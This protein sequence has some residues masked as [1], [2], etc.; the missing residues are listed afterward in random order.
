MNEFES[1]IIEVLQKMEND[2]IA[3]DEYLK[4]R[5]RRKEDLQI[6]HMKSFF[7]M[8]AFKKLQSLAPSYIP[9]ES[10]GLKIAQELNTAGNFVSIVNNQVVISPDYEEFLK[11]KAEYKNQKNNGQIH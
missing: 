9:G 8:I 6:V 5:T 7:D 2:Q 3:Y 4:D 11:L 10:L 1:K